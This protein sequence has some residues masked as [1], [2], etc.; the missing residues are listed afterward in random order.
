MALVVWFI[1]VLHVTHE[2]YWLVDGKPA[3]FLASSTLV[4]HIQCVP[5]GKTRCCGA[6]LMANLPT[7]CAVTVPTGQKTVF[8]NSMI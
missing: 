8:P 7:V 5:A 6:F 3:I 1:F 4:M 2:H